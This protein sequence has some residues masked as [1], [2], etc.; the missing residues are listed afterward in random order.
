MRDAATAKER[1][2]QAVQAMTWLAKLLASDRSFYNLHRAAPVVEAALYRPD[3]ANLAIS[4]LSEL[5]TPESQQLL[6]NYASETTL[7]PAAR[8][9]RRLP[10][11]GQRRQVRR[12]IDDGCNSR[13]IRSLQRQCHSG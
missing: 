1:A 13:P 10:R 4:A 3:A 8:A 11:S 6:V 9:D 7:P 2:A 12:A 5:G